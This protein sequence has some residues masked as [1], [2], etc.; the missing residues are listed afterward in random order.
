MRYLSGTPD[1]GM[2]IIDDY[3]CQRLQALKGKDKTALVMEFKEWLVETSYEEDEVWTIPDLTDEGLC[4]FFKRAI[5][6]K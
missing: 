1:K 5:S 2:S 3:L 4:D 6:S